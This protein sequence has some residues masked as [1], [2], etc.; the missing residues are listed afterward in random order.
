[1]ESYNLR[2]V[3]DG[4]L[5][6]FDVFQGICERNHL[7]FYMAYRSALGTV[8]HHGFIPWDD[9]LD[10]CMPLEDYQRFM[11]IAPKELPSYLKLHSWRTDPQYRRNFNV[12]QDT[13]VEVQKR[14]E[15]QSGLCIR[16]VYMDIFPIVGVPAS[17]IGF[18]LWMAGRFHLRSINEYWRWKGHKRRMG[19]RPVLGF[20]FASC[21]KVKKWEHFMESMDRWQAKRPFI[22]SKATTTPFTARNWRVPPEDWGEPVTM[23][24]EGRKVPMPKEY[25]L[26]L[27]LIYGD[28][29]KLPPE[30]QRRPAHPIKK[31]PVSNG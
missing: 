23:E 10:V 9:D 27:R 14:I 3:W 5:S 31:K 28:Y 30:E 7:R 20:L 6:I 15:E 12:I 16:S 26:I 18:W 4:I 11:D 8:R 17:T 29:M 2:P 25:D 19:L 13:R 24:F 21:S 22:G 1:M